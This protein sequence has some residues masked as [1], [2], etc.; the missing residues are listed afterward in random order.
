VRDLVG[1]D[2]A[3]IVD[4]LRLTTDVAARRYG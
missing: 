1:K 4:A 3:H 2:K